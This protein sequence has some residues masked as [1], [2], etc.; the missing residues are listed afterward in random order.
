MSSHLSPFVVRWLTACLLLLALPVTGLAG[1]IDSASP[2]G[3]DQWVQVIVFRSMDRTA[4]RH[5]RWGHT[6]PHGVSSIGVDLNRPSRFPAGFH[7][8]GLGSRM[9]RIWSILGASALYHPTAET[10]MDPTRPSKGFRHTGGA[11]FFSEPAPQC[12]SHK[13][14]GARLIY[15]EQTRPATGHGPD[16]GHA[17]CLHRGSRPARQKQPADEPHACTGTDIR[18]PASHPHSATPLHPLSDQSGR[19][20]SP[21][22]SELFR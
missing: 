1:T 21:R 20:V 16:H 9:R 4:G 6:L 17:P 11:G 22:S 8:A 13:A 12:H 2:S 18:E 3:P 7:S 14:D 15:G 5:E 10:G 19:P